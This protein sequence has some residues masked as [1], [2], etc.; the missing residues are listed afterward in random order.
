IGDLG[1]TANLA[2]SVTLPPMDVPFA[3]AK[4]QFEYE[5]FRTL[6]E[7]HRGNVA[8]VARAAGLDPSNVRRVLRRHDLQAQAFR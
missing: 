6:L 7:K 8:G 1:P 5:Y 2:P 3:D 4:R